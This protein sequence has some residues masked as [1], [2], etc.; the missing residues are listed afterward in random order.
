MKTIRISLLAI[1]AL[2]VISFFNPRQSFSAD[3]NTNITVIKPGP[4][5]I[6]VP[7]H[8]IHKNGKKVWIQGH[9]KKV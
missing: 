3:A 9:W 5:Y 8:F 7:G 6:W 4:K 2:F 1:T